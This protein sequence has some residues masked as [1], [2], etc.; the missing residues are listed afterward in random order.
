MQASNFFIL[1]KLF[2]SLLTALD[3]PDAPTAL[4]HVEEEYEGNN[5]TLELDHTVDEVAVGLILFRE[6]TK[7]IITDI[8][9]AVLSI[10]MMVLSILEV[11]YIIQNA[12]VN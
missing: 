3:R 1:I 2:R 8:V 12:I 6:Q 9:V 7:L 11:S 5:T 4:S 10:A